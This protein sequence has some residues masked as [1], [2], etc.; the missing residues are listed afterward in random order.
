M[1]YDQLDKDHS[2]P[3]VGWAVSLFGLQAPL[4]GLPSHSSSLESAAEHS[5]GRGLGQMDSHRQSEGD[6][7][8]E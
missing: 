7:E 5:E 3:G 4:L 2:T 1:D 8:A 6:T